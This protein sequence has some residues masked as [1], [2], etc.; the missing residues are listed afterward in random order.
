MCA[1]PARSSF[2]EAVCR[3]QL[4]Q[5][6]AER[7]RSRGTRS[8]CVVSLGLALAASISGC[9]S[10]IEGNLCLATLPAQVAHHRSLS[11]RHGFNDMTHAP[12]SSCPPSHRLL[13]VAT[14]RLARRRSQPQRSCRL[15]LD[16]RSPCGSKGDPIRRSRAHGQ[17]L[18][19]SSG[20]G[21]PQR[22]LVPPARVQ[23][24]LLDPQVARE[25]RN[26]QR[27]SG[28]SFARLAVIS[29]TR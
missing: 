20:F 22:G 7:G 2:K 13:V 21:E 11:S 19:L 18:L 24:A 29:A 10:S 3:R 28:A 9:R 1:S 27:S 6:D 16:E 5:P 14:R 17:G 23:H 15:G 8:G 25:P 4:L 12:S 26:R